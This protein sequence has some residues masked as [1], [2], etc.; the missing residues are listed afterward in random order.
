MAN[1]DLPVGFQPMQRYDGAA[2]TAQLTPYQFAS[3]F[4]T[5]VF[6]YDV[7]KL[8]TDGTVAPAAA[9]DQWRG[10]VMGFQWIATNGSVMSGPYWP[11]SNVT[12]NSAPVQVLLCDDPNQN[13]VVKLTGSSTAL[14]QAAIGATFNLSAATA[15]NTAT[16][17][18]GM[19]LNPSTLATS[20]QQFRLQGFLP[21]N[22]N[23]PTA[24]YARV[25]VAP[26]LQDYRVNT[27][28]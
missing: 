18:S 4:G 24:A 13:Y 15:G 19:G 2:L 9:G 1:V 26:A 14:T 12:L 25:V 6:L 3:G 11:A 8:L 5:N 23:D 28:I 22:Y 27:G 7:M 10:V 17:I 16:G 20:A 21:N